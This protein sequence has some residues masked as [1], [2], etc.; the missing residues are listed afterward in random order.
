M[1]LTNVNLYEKPA[2]I[3]RLKDPIEYENLSDPFIEASFGSIDFEKQ[4]SSAY[5]IRLEVLRPEI[6]RTA[7]NR[8]VSTG[9]IPESQLVGHVKSYK[10]GDRDV[11]LVGVLFKD[12]KLKPNVLT[13]IQ[14]NLKI[15]DQFLEYPNISSISHRLE[16]DDTVFLEDMEARLQLVFSDKSILDGLPTGVVVAVLGRINDQGF[17]EVRD[18]CLPGYS[19]MH[20]QITDGRSPAYVAIVSGL[21]IGAPNTDPL[22]IQLLRD[23]I[24]GVSVSSEERELSSKIIRMVLAGDS[25]YASV[26]RDPTASCLADADVFLSELASALPVDVMSGPRDPTNYCLPQQPLHSGLF[27]E[28]RRY[29]NLSVHTNPYKFRLGDMVMLGTSGQNVTDIIQYTSA[30]DAVAALDLIAQSRYLAPTAPD[31]LGCYPFT[32]VDPLVIEPASVNLIFAGNQMDSNVKFVAEGKLCLASIADFAVSASIL[33]VNVNDIHDT[34]VIRFDVP[35][36]SE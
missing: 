34:K 21:R 5:F 36:M 18:M 27:P 33:L 9:L 28:G 20:R 8:W 24:M 22:A 3:Q 16:A 35:K 12:M 29:K 15:A 25:I 11:A 13:D 31:T 10:S 19:P 17:F 1:D 2:K 30:E 7:A 4:Y 23:F 6:S 32:T 26:D 14:E